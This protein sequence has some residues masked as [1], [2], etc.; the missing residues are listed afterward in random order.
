MNFDRNCI[1]STDC[2]CDSKS[3]LWCSHIV[4]LALYRI[5]N[6]NSIPLKPPISDS[7]LDLKQDQLQKLLLLLVSSH[8]N[9][10]LPVVQTLLDGL[11]IPDSEISSLTGIPDP[12]AGG[13]YEDSYTWHMD[14]EGIRKQITQNL[15]EGSAGKN[16]ISLINKVNI[17]IL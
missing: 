1:T 6:S 4:A 7:V 9:K 10:I 11:H 13:C 2:T 14:D 12:T 17:F 3:L 5:R 16:I 8:R 15:S